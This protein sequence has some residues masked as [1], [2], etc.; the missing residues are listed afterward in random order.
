MAGYIWWIGVAV[1]AWKLFGLAKWV[2]FHFVQKPQDWT[3][4][5]GKFAL[6]T[7]A[8]GGIGAAIANVLARHGFASSPDLIFFFFF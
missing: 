4:Y 2:Y 1:V 6:V 7:G 3:K 5:K 8:S